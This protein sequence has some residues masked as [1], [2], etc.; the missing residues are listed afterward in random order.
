MSPAMPEADF[1]LKDRSNPSRDYVDTDLARGPLW[2]PPVKADWSAVI[3]D[4]CRFYRNLHSE[5]SRSG[6]QG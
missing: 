5:W 3:S 1:R 6:G 2:R 4:R